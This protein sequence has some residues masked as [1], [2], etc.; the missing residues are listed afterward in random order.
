MSICQNYWPCWNIPLCVMNLY[1]VIQKVYEVAKVI[2]W[3]FGKWKGTVFRIS[4]RSELL[5]LKLCIVIHYIHHNVMRW[6]SCMCLS[7]LR[8][9]RW[10]SSG[11]GEM[12]WHDTGFSFYKGEGKSASGWEKHVL[13]CWS[14]QMHCSEG[15]GGGGSVKSCTY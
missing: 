3:K 12:R 5:F 7:P 11:N 1:R 6:S 9:V 4:S 2:I 15:G 13:S 8:Y 10:Q 14:Q